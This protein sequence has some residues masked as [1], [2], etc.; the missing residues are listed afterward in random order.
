M[1]NINDVSVSDSNFANIFTHDM[2]QNLFPPQFELIPQL[3]EVYELELAKL[4]IIP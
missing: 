3:N 4:F 2:Y 1:K